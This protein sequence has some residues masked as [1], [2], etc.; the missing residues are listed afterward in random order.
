VRLSA[1][2]H[3]TLYEIAWGVQLARARARDLVAITPSTI[4]GESVSEKTYIDFDVAVVVGES[5]TNIKGG[6]GKTGAEIQVASII[7]ASIG[8][9][10]TI[11]SNSTASKEQTHRVAFK[12]PVYMNA[13]FRNNPLAASDAKDL[14]AAHG[15]SEVS[16]K[17]SEP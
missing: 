12:V 1:F 13:H 17:P 10:G 11:E 7:K 3:D 14:L 8:G 2:I 15:I 4:D 9:E 16:P 5:E 6:G